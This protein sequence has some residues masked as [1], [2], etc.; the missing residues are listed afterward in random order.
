[1][2]RGPQNPDARAAPILSAARKLGFSVG[3]ARTPRAEAKKSAAPSW[4]A[5]IVHP[6][7]LATRLRT[8]TLVDAIV[9]PGE[10]SFALAKKGSGVRATVSHG[11][12][13][14]SISLRGDAGEI[15]GWPAAPGS[16]E[17]AV[18]HGRSDGDGWKLDRYAPRLAPLLACFR[19]AYRKWANEFYR[20]EL[21]PEA[22][23]VLWWQRDRLTPEIVAALNPKA[24]WRSVA[25]EAA[26]L[27][28]KIA[29][30]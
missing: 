19:P 17:T 20:R 21:A 25:R 12:A 14:L 13:T 3:A 30:R 5:E 22:M 28:F 18:L 11:G 15:H 2:P 6:G 8:F 1:M 16:L 23:Q 27:G 9:S 7:L 4:L 29:K 10:R 26:V 24:S